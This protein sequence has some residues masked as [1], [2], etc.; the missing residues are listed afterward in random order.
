MKKFIC[1]FLAVLCA[2]SVLLSTAGC[3][4]GTGSNGNESQANDTGADSGDVTTKADKVTVDEVEESIILPRE[5][6]SVIKNFKKIVEMR[7]SENFEENW[8]NGEYRNTYEGYY[9]D[10]I[11][12]DFDI[13]ITEMLLPG[14]NV[15]SSSYGCVL[16]DING[17]D[18]LELF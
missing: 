10:S 1:V 14:D 7:L 13:M 17:D 12:G 15:T 9:D 5:Y 4:S 18:V 6:E 8:N 2:F 16:K 3:T 11:M